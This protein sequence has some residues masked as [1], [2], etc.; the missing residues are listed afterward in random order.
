MSNLRFRINSHQCNYEN[1]GPKKVHLAF[2]DIPFLSLLRL[3]MACVVTLNR[4]AID[5]CV[6]Y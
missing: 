4:F 3:V 5:N 1:W 2:D 6:P